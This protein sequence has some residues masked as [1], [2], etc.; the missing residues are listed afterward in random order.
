MKALLSFA[1]GGPETLRVDEIADP[2]AGP[3]EVLIRVR[4]CG[5]NYPDLLVIEDKYQFQPKR[6]FSPG[7]EIAG[8]IVGVGEGVDGF[9]VGDRIL[10]MMGIGGMAE[11]VAAPAS[12]CI[13]IPDEMPFDE[14]AAFIAAFGTSYHALRQR[15]RLVPGERLLVLGAAGGMGLAAVELGRAM[16][17]HVIAAASSEDKL[18]LARRHGATDGFVYPADIGTVDPK[19]LA[20]M[21][22]SAVGDQGVDIVYDP[23]GGAYAEAAL[24]SIAWRGRFLIIGFPAGIPKIPLN[25]PLLK[26]CEI[27]GVFYGSFFEREPEA[28][29]ENVRA[30]FRIYRE[31]KIRPHIA[32]RLSLEDAARGFEI[33]ASRSA[34]GKIIIALD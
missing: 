13:A 29:M 31:G 11:L 5:V 18:A 15:G 10:S 22:K 3:G 25:L 30:L 27:V 34:Q 4:A 12:K 16:G 20:A 2:I 32:A 21:F 33:L 14:G 6:P 7:G 17:A 23:V 8:E 24:R 9:A 19:A 26:G 1:S 28:N